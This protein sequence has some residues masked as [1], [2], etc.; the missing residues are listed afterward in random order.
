MFIDPADV[1]NI[2]Q[3]SIT[4]EETSDRLT[5]S[6]LK[7]SMIQST[8]QIELPDATKTN[9]KPSL[10]RLNKK[11]TGH[12]NLNV[13]PSSLLFISEL[14]SSFQTTNTIIAK[15]EQRIVTFEKDVAFETENKIEVRDENLMHSH[16]TATNNS[17]KQASVPTGF[18]ITEEIDENSPTFPDKVTGKEPSTLNQVSPLTED[19]DF[20]SP[21][22]ESKVQS[23]SSNTEIKVMQD[24]S[25]TKEY[26][27]ESHVTN[28]NVMDDSTA[29]VLD[30][31]ATKT[32]TIL[33]LTPSE[34]V[35]NPFMADLQGLLNSVNTPEDSS[36][37]I[38]WMDIMK[39][40][41]SPL[42]QSET[43]GA[44]FFLHETTT[45]SSSSI[46]STI[47]SH[48]IADSSKRLKD[49]QNDPAI[50]H[51]YSANFE[52]SEITSNTIAYSESKSN[53]IDME[54]ISGIEINSVKPV[55]NQSSFLY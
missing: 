16:Q 29:S 36:S 37:S 43:E 49:V 4:N 25:N 50:T 13:K 15:T 47:T 12:T 27:H 14:E 54:N 52:P 1:K 20:V 35:T 9:L 34:S 21:I 23:E 18:E 30:N 8:S 3:S 11:L 44:D 32:N 42:S 53:S 10:R 19:Q 39:K 22:V 51:G 17:N 38:G 7:S 40:V 46:P 48:F 5:V 24:L 2:V 26:S 55:I 6:Y 31:M 41:I 33:S 28:V 45:L